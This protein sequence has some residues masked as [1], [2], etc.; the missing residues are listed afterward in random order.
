M[1]HAFRVATLL[2]TTIVCLSATGCRLR[3]PASVPVRTIEP[4]LLEP[5][6]EKPEKQVT[7]A[8]DA[9]PIR[10]LD[11]NVQGSMGRHVVHQQANGE[12][13][14]DPVWRWSAPPERYLDMALRMQLEASPSMRRVDSSGAPTLAATLLVWDLESREGTQ[15]V[16]AAEFQ[17]TWADRA[18][19]T[20]LVRDSEPVLAERPGDLPLAAGRLL[21][22]L[23]SRGLTLAASKR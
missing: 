5:Q 4:Q 15:L 18:V 2:V 14:T 7:K 3:R 21:R 9:T 16:G 13:L 23:A 12:L 20:Q 6:I 19:N 8:P 11:T 17:V 10:L 1:T 22:R